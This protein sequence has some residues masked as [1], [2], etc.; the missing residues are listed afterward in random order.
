VSTVGFITL[1]LT[2]AEDNILQLEMK[3]GAKS[4]NV[5]EVAC[6][7]CKYTVIYI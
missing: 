5:G 3:T 1:I 6:K 2:T 4:K 7:G